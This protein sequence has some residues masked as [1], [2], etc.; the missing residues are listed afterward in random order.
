MSSGSEAQLFHLN[1]KELE[2]NS[3]IY[4]FFHVNILVFA[5]FLGVKTLKKG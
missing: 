5:Y 4:A 2:K 1:L 3:V